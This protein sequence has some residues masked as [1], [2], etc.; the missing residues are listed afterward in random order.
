MAL[1]AVAKEERQFVL[2]RIKPCIH[3]GNIVCA[4]E[5]A[6]FLA[7]FFLRVAREIF[8]LGRKSDDNDATVARQREAVAERTPTLIPLFDALTE[9]TRALASVPSQKPT[10]S[11]GA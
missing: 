8:R 3:A 6:F 7:E 4:D 2:I 11:L 10:P 5:V 1:R 9:A